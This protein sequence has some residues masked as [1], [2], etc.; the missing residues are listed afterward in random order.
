MKNKPPLQVLKFRAFT[1]HKKVQIWMT[2]CILN[3][4][5]SL[6]CLYLAQ[7]V[8][9]TLGCQVD[10]QN[11]STLTATRPEWVRSNK[12]SGNMHAKQNFN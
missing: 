10:C 2:E 12:V 7:P 11:I 6:S 3:K 8:S 5:F 1:I 9:L 4:G